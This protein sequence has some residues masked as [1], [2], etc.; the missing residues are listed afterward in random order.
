MNDFSIQ[1]AAAVSSLSESVD[2]FQDSPAQ[3]HAVLDPVAAMG[4][5]GS[6]VWGRR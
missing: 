2:S 3:L 6:W 4:R 5:L 1:I